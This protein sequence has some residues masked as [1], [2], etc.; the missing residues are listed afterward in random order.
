MFNSTST[1]TT[2]RILDYAAHLNNSAYPIAYAPF[3]VCTNSGSICVRSWSRAINVNLTNYWG[4]FIRKKIYWLYVK[5]LYEE[6]LYEISIVYFLYQMY[7]KFFCNRKK[8]ENMWKNFY[9]LF[10]LLIVFFNKK[11]IM[12]FIKI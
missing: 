6:D 4:F 2:C 10:F 3:S 7:R 1:S 11:I 9:L 8:N 5:N 12:N